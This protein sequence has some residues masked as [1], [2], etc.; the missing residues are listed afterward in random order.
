[1]EY[2]MN[3]SDNF[4]STEEYVDPGRNNHLFY[5]IPYE[6]NGAEKL[7]TDSQELYKWNLLNIIKQLL[8][9]YSVH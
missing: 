8:L 4:S 7:N 9:T 6:A 2:F 3:L 1:M 5:W